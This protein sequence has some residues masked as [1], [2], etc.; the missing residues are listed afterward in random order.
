MNLFKLLFVTLCLVTLSFGTTVEEMNKMFESKKELYK[1]LESKFIIYPDFDKVKRMEY[2]AKMFNLLNIEFIK[3]ELDKHPENKKDLFTIFAPYINIYSYY[4]VKYNYQEV[5]QIQSCIF[6]M[7]NVLKYTQE[8]GYLETLAFLMARNN[9]FE[10][11]FNF[12]PKTLEEFKD[13]KETFDE[14][15][16]N[17]NVIKRIAFDYATKTN[18]Q[19]L[20]N[21]VK[22]FN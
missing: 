8:L 4:I 15:Q 22:E 1:S 19:E 16:E 17:F 9:E 3:S 7:A 20:L 12:Y 10:L 18:N 21:K 13:D 2:D 5:K 14:L 6:L 11:A